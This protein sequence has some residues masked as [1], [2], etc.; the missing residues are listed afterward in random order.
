MEYKGDEQPSLNNA[1]QPHSL[2]QVTVPASLLP[3]VLSRLGLED[4]TSLALTGGDKQLAALKD[5][6][7]SVRVAAV[8]GLEEQREANAIESLLA[9][10]H[11]SAWEVRAA[12]AWELGKFGEQAP[13]EALLRA[14]DAEDGSVRSAA[15]RTLGSMGDR[16]SLESLVRALDDSDWQV[17]E[18]A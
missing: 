16:V 7:I 8:R 6:E 5:E 4:M 9:A 3:S 11:D 18:I 12:A 10:L 13:L 1:G 2:E 14:T 17:R 15:L